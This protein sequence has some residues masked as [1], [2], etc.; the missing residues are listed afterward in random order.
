[1]IGTAFL[2][3]SVQ[4]TWGNLEYLL[5]TVRLLLNLR[6]YV[7]SLTLLARAGSA[8]LYPLQDIL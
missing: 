2:R 8:H 6:Y 4:P 7:N 3:Y 1:M 5:G